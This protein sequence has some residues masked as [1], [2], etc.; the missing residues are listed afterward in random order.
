MIWFINSLIAFLVQATLQPHHDLH[1]PPASVSGI[2]A[3]ALRGN[4]KVS[5]KE[6][7]GVYRHCASSSGALFARL[8]RTLR[9]SACSFLSRVLRVWQRSSALHQIT[10][11]DS[12]TSIK[13]MGINQLLS[14]PLSG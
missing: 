11:R 7:G 9:R 1:P 10:D 2:S 13:P 6:W 3:Q 4:G 5:R 8:A 12:T 14:P